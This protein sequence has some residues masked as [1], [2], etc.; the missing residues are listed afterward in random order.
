MN[1]TNVTSREYIQPNK[2]VFC[3]LNFSNAGTYEIELESTYAIDYE[4]Y[5]ED[6]DVIRSGTGSS[7]DI[8]MSINAGTYYLRM[9]FDSYTGS[10]YV[11]ISIHTHSYTYRWLSE[12]QHRRTCSGCGEISTA[13][14]VVAQG[15]FPTPEGYAICI[16]C[17]GRVFMGV[18]YN[19]STN[20]LYHS[21]NGSYILPNGVVVL[22]EEDID[23]YMAGTL[24]FYTG[25]ID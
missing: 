22:V 9:N 20:G 7:N 4:I 10:H 21:A 17:R 8:S 1:T 14:H 13:A 18:L 5:D 2:D 11:D 25:E 19:L 12:T 24:E 6:F 3:E 15:A 16:Q 23:A